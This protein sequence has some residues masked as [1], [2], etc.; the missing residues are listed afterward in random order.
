MSEGNPRQKGEARA[1]RKTMDNSLLTPIELSEN[2]ELAALRILKTTLDV[3]EL[4]LLASYPESCECSER[5]GTEQE[6]YA[7]A[8]LYQIDAL[9]V[10]LNQY[11]ESLRRVGEWRNREASKEDMLF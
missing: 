8:I 9:A 7:I 10:L 1:M 11:V 3:A 6:A 5:R 4:A 2:P